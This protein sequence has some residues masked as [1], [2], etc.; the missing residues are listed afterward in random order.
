MEC[1]W[2]ENMG[3]GL[4]NSPYLGNRASFVNPIAAPFKEVTL[5]ELSAISFLA[6][7]GTEFEKAKTRTVFEKDSMY[8]CN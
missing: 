7:L 5:S 2:F 4:R 1:S 3:V 8:T 6:L